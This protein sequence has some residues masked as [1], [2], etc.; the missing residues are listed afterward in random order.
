LNFVRFDKRSSE[1]GDLR[2]L[3]FN[4]SNTRDP[5]SL[6]PSLLEGIPFDYVIFTTNENG[7]NKILEDKRNQCQMSVSWQET[8]RD[9]WL[10]EK[11][12]S[13]VEVTESITEAIKKMTKYEEE[14]Q[15]ARVQVLITG[16]FYLVGGFLEILQPEMC[17]SV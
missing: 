5:S 2:I 4:C 13:R 1:K 17:D 8:L 12:T 9:K 3:V 16:S 10:K 14:N 15:K 6:F 7:K 11:G